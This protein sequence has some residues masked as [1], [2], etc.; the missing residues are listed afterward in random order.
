MFEGVSDQAKWCCPAW[1]W[2][3]SWS[4]G[5]VTSFTLV[6]MINDVA[7]FLILL[8]LCLI[9]VYSCAGCWHRGVVIA[10]TFIHPMVDLGLLLLSNSCSTLFSIF[11]SALLDKGEQSVQ[12]AS[13]NV[14][15]MRM[16]A[17]VLIIGVLWLCEGKVT[18]HSNWERWRGQ[19]LW[20]PCCGW[21][22]E[23]N[24]AKIQPLLPQQPMQLQAWHLLSH[25][26]CCLSWCPAFT[27]L[28]IL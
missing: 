7:W 28:W 12:L 4:P 27:L 22:I 9:P 11:W 16:L 5:T 24:T 20:R 10:G 14:S 1:T 21:L 2:N 17:C 25:T 26:W 23:D 6:Y 8:I 13:L 19:H 3:P 15:Q 18:T